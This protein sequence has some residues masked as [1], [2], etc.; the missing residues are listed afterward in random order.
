MIN[1]AAKTISLQ[2]SE[3]KIMAILVKLLPG[4]FPRHDVD[5]AFEA[6]D[7]QDRLQEL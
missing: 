1:A 2:N 3:G 5:E 6:L 7:G 4:R